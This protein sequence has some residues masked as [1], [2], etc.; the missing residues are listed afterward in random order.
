MSDDPNRV[1]VDGV[2]W[3]NLI[4]ALHLFGS[5]RMAIGPAK[6]FLAIF[7]VILTYLGGLALDSIWGAQVHSGELGAYLNLPP[8][9]YAQWL[10][11]R[12]EE[13][14]LSG[15]F[16]TTLNEQL[17]AFQQLLVSALSLDFG[18]HGFLTRTP[19]DAGGVMG[20]LVKMVLGIPGWLYRTHTGFLVIFLIYVFL[21][22]ATFGGA[23]SRLAALQATR[24]QYLSPFEA[25]RFNGRFFGWFL[26][27]PIIPLALV[28][29]IGL[30]MALVGLLFNLP[31]TDVAASLLF[32]LLLACGFVIALLLVGFAGASN[33]LFPAI[34]VEGTDAFDAI[35]RAF[36]YVLQRPWR[37]ILYSVTALVYGAI[38]YTFVAFVVY[39]ILWATKTFVGLWVYAEID[40]VGRFDAILPDPDL[41]RLPFHARGTPPGLD[42]GWSV[43]A[44]TAI[45]TV[46]VKLLIGLLP[47]FAFSY[48]FCAQTWI[49]LLL[50]QNADGTE[51]EM[52]YLDEDADGMPPAP[53]PEKVE[54]G[55]EPLAGDRG[56]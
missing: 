30:F 12:S 56:Q 16:A 28:L 14:K 48:Y 7:M 53:V 13:E 4:P 36:S 27:A 49:Y 1:R 26:L 43:G 17:R 25:L 50:R 37:F 44:A 45:V 42:G 33:L 32:G 15:I 51:I 54:G 55:Q 3:Q 52:V 9:E 2:D 29:G 8:S 22:T 41:Q 40:G 47:A 24:D 31:V 11:Q 20:A 18:F 39:L 21:L 23:I 5:F 46:W 19:A 10:E 38:T 34:A 6:L 35:S